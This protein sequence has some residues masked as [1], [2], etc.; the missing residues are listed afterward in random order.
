MTG[1]VLGNPVWVVTC[2]GPGKVK[3]CC[4]LPAAASVS[5]EDGGESAASCTLML[6]WEARSMDMELDS[7]P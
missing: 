1:L 4:G 5:E 3:G 6:G 2:L 7:T